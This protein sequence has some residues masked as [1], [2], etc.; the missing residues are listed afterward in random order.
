MSSP[1]AVV[2][3]QL[4]AY[5]ARDL[6]AFLA[7][8]ADDVRIWRL[9]DAQPLFEGRAQVAAHYGGKVFQRAGLRAEVV[10]RLLL[11]SK[12]IDHERA[13]WDGL[14]EPIEAVAIYEVRDGLIRNVWFVEP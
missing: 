8:Y 4:E 9:A 5:N 1:A 10:S 13:T 12:V 6:D 2:Q 11:G 14:A 3:R 7:T